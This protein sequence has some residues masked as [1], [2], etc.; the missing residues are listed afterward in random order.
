MG[1]APQSGLKVLGRLRLKIETI[2]C[3]HG[4]GASS[5]SF[6]ELKEHLG[7][8]EF[9][10]P[11]CPGHAKALGEEYQGDALDFAAHR[12]ADV[13]K[14]SGQKVVL[15]GHSMGGALALLVLHR[16][17][18]QIAAVVSI[19]GNMIAEDCGLIS[20]KLALAGDVGEIERLRQGLVETAQKSE[21]AGWWMW[22]EEA[23]LMGPQA[24]KDYAAS[25][26][27]HSDSGELIKTFNAFS[28]PKAYI[29]GDGYVGHVLLERMDAAKSFHAVGADHFVMQD[30]PAYC[31][32][33]I[34]QVLELVK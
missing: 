33:V 15:V 8:Y 6:D 28:G 12:V 23:A 24:L 19:E 21:S 3:L 18:E 7:L 14:A 22:A 30:K 31:A 1:K 29:H 16:V 9:I 5:A 13:I 10:T 34:K 11:D 4:L 27:A 25:L 17:P 32:G 20:R 2:I 26:V